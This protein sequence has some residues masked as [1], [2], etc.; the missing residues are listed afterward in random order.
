MSAK[1]TRTGGSLGAVHK[2]ARD[3]WIDIFKNGNLVRGHCTGSM[4]EVFKLTKTLNLFFSKTGF[5]FSP[6]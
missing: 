1:N 6:T 3:Y 4:F 2:V 5:C